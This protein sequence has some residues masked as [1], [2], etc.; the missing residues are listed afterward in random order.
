MD[1]RIRYIRN[2]DLVAFHCNAAT[3]LIERFQDILKDLTIYSNN[4]ISQY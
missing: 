1:I 3:K 4:I 2:K